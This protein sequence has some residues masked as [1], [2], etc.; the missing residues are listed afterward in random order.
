MAFNL[1]D[2]STAESAKQALQKELPKGTTRDKVITFLD[3]ARIACFD[4]EAEVLACRVVEKSSTMVHV[5]W[6]LA[7]HFDSRRRLADIAV[8]RGF[9]GP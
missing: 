3:A 2:Y 8:T 4:K 5:V 6:Q 1:T 9:T 7:F